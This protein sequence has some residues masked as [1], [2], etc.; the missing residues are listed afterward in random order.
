MSQP[1]TAT[2]EPI[3]T[4]EETTATPKKRGWFSRKEKKPPRPLLLRLFGISIWDGLKLAVL[5]VV[6]GFFVLAAQ[7]D[8]REPDVNIP[9]AIGAMAQSTFQAAGWAARNFW[10]PALAG[11]GIV[12]PIWV[13]WRLVSLPFRT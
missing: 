8:P 1:P 9:G 6:I 3:V 5:C 11:A 4:V 13:L 2:E 10:K 7:F 12:L